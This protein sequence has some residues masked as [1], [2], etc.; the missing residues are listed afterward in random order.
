M[1]L[2]SVM[3]MASAAFAARWR[4]PRPGNP[5]TYGRALRCRPNGT[6]GIFG[7]GRLVPRLR[8]C[9]PR[10]QRK[11]ADDTAPARVVYR[12]STGRRILV[13]KHF[14]GRDL[15]LK[16]ESGPGTGFLGEIPVGRMAAATEAVLFLAALA[17]LA[18]ITRAR[19]CGTGMRLGHWGG[20][21]RRLAL[22]TC[23]VS[24]LAYL[25]GG[26]MLFKRGAPVP[27]MLTT[28]LAF[29]L[30]GPAAVGASREDAIPLRLLG[31]LKHT[32]PWGG[33]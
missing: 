23:F 6:Q 16:D 8:V 13:R 32:L 22:L 10:Q 24:C 28:A 11:C 5:Y 12:P 15:N 3:P 31:D 29:L 4:H 1:E 19:V 9:L 20:G 21:M 14:T 27:T 33:R 30:L 7:I 25:G 26:P 18:L 17:T 2:R